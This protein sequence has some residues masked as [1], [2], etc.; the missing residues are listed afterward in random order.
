MS[1]VLIPA[2]LILFYFVFLRPQQQRVRKQRALLNA[3]SVGDEIVTAGGMIGRIVDL[4]DERAVVEVA[5]GVEIE[6]LRAAI[7]RKLDPSEAPYYNTSDSESYDDEEADD[8]AGSD[9]AASHE[10]ATDE[11]ATHET[12]THET[13]THETATHET[14]THD[15]GP[16]DANTHDGTPETTGHPAA[17]Q[18]NHPTKNEGS[19]IPE[20]DKQ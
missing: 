16:H 13:A 14:A 1:I 11:T 12:A 6:F 19:D 20:Q 5:H 4:T 2:L 15:A 7:S 10:P 3:L 8:A 9:D 17:N 18:R